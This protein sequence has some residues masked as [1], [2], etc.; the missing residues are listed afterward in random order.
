MSKWAFCILCAVILI[1]PGFADA[2]QNKTDVSSLLT[3]GP[4]EIQLRDEAVISLPVVKSSTGSSPGVR[5]SKDQY[6]EVKIKDLKD[7]LN[8]AVEPQN[9]LVHDEA[10]LMVAKLSESGDSTI[11]QICSIY[12][13]LKNGDG[14]IKGWVYVSDPRGL[15]YFSYANESVN[16]GDKS[17]STGA[18]DCDDFAVL[19]ASLIESIGGTTRI[20]LAYDNS[21]AGHAYAE[22]YLGK[23]NSQDN[24]VNEIIDWLE[25]KYNTEKIFTYNDTDTGEVW[26]NMDWGPDEKG[27]LHP[28]GPF[29]PGDIKIVIAVRD[30]FD[31]IPLKLPATKNEPI[32]LI[33]NPAIQLN[34]TVNTTE[35]NSSEV[36]F[37]KGVALNNL[38]R[39][40]EAIKSYDLAIQLNPLNA[41]AWDNKGNALFSQGRLDDALQAYNKVI[42]LDN[43]S[44]N[45][46]GMRGYILIHKKDPQYEEALISLER[47][48]ELEPFTA[49]YWNEKG[50]ALF[51]LG[52][53]EDALEAK[54]ESIKLN[55]TLY[56]TWYDRAIVLNSMGRYDE[57][58]DSVN[59]SI[60]LNSQ[61]EDCWTLKDYV[62][63]RLNKSEKEVKST[64]R[65][66]VIAS[67]EDTIADPGNRQPNNIIV[68]V[69]DINGVPVAGLEA[70]NFKVDPMIGTLVNITDVTEGKLHGF[71]NIDVVPIKAETWKKAVYIFAV[72][73]E[74]G[75][76][77]GQTLVNVLID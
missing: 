22:V 27:N 47:A 70:S 2:L 61:D 18:G 5:D 44:S 75:S 60:D 35:S 45:A 30:D 46:W 77:S 51:Y 20:I 15:D 56:F 29:C 50:N 74:N 71:Y 65:L 36:L 62:L 33:Q 55:P 59:K 54:N 21:T 8:N 3:L 4:K 13:Y 7:M 57:A 25:E 53:Y 1:V 17:D 66:I 40:D 49:W 42:D 26:L 67:S 19:M 76:D 34:I 43:K 9:T 38:G 63:L 73:V 24:Q 11:N 39:Y 37:N 64:A 10:L 14:P 6:R 48:I 68:S 69:T 52:K 32:K 31:R 72:A 16:I 28:G 12:S 23:L 41:E 58:L